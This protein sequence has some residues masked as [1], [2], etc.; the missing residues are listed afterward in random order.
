MKFITKH[1]PEL[2]YI[3]IF[4]PICVYCNLCLAITLPYLYLGA[5]SS[6]GLMLTAIV[7]L[8]EKRNP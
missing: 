5:I 2:T 8:R 6:G 4:T 7:A 3:I 1:I